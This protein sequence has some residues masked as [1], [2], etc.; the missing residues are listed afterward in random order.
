MMRRNRYGNWFREAGRGHLAAGASW[1]SLLIYMLVMLMSLS[2]DTEYT[3]FGIGNDGGLFYLC[4]GL[5]FFVGIVEF[6][7]LFQ[8]RKLDFYYSLPVS[9][10]TVFWTRY[11]H[12]IIHGLLPLTVYLFVCGIYEGNLDSVFLPYSVGYTFRS[13]FAYGLVYLLFYH[14]TVC[15]MTLCGRMASAVV[16]MAAFMFCLKVIIQDVWFVFIENLYETFYRISMLDRLETWLFPLTLGRSLGG[17]GIYDKTEALVYKPEPAAYVSAFVWIVVLLCITVL[18]QRKRKTEST[19]RLFASGGAERFAEA[20]LSV[21]VGLGVGGLAL[22]LTDISS[23]GLFPAASVMAVIGL[24]AGAGVH[25]LLEY[26]IRKPNVKPL[27]RK[28]QWLAEEA[29]I[30]L[31]VLVLAVI[32]SPFDSFMPEEE[33]VEELGICVAGLN[34]SRE[35]YLSC[36]RSANEYLTDRRLELCTL[37]GEGKTAG[38]AWLRGVQKEALPDIDAEEVKNDLYTRVTVCYHMKDGSEKYRTYLTD[39]ETLTEFAPVFESKEYKAALYPVPELTKSEE[40]QFTWSDGIAAQTLLFSGEEKNELLECYETDIGEM[41]MSD[42][43]TEFPAGTVEIRSEELGRTTELLVYPFFENTCAFLNRH[44]VQTG[45]R[46]SDYDV[47]EIRGS[48]TIEGW[49]GDK[50]GTVGGG[51]LHFS[52]ET[53]EEIAEWAARLVP[54]EFDVQPIL[55]PLDHTVTAE[56]KVNVPEYRAVITVDCIG[57]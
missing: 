32:A 13:L 2:L 53:E 14:I 46:L 49:N 33:D 43:E 26:L 21:T 51:Q 52:A 8:E 34:M 42:L 41:T 35:D 3:F 39:V 25:I 44:G 10:S 9:K 16:M 24:L 20:I 40:K 23:R 27:R 28:G 6:L 15:A 54:E 7:Y 55:C 37:S 57:Q 29:V 17:V 12:G 18:I 30:C 31:T 5:G 50:P 48:E 19:G 47:K 36:V 11:L 56:A 38:M 4:G 1:G 22:R 45:K